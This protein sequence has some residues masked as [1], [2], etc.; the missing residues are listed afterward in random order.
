MK[1]LV[2]TEKYSPHPSQKDGGARV[3]ESLKQ[4][5]GNDVSI[6]QFGGFEKSS[7][8]WHFDYPHTYPCRFMNRIAN[9]PFIAEKVKAVEE[10]FTHIIFI[11]ASMQFGYQSSNS[12]AWTFPMF[13]TPSYL[14]SGEDIPSEYT[15]LE[16]QVLASTHNILSPS[17]LEKNQIIDFYDIPERKIHVVP[18]GVDTTMLRPQT[19]KLTSN[20]KFCSVGSI[21]TQKNTIGLL[22]LFSKAKAKYPGATL[23][24][25]GPIQ[26]SKYHSKVLEVL[27]R[28]ELKR[29]V[30]FMG[31][32]SPQHISKA[33]E[34]CHI[35]ISA[36]SYET[37]GRSIFETLASGLPNIAYKQGN[38]AAEFLDGLPYAQFVNCDHGFLQAIDFLLSDLTRLSRMSQE[39]GKLFNDKSLAQQLVA[40]VISEDVI[41][42]SDFDGTLYHKEDEIKTQTCIDEFKKFKVKVICS[43]R[44]TE[45][46]LAYCER[47]SLNVDW[48]VSYGGAVVSDGRGNE[49][50]RVPIGKTDVENIE[51]LASE[52]QRIMT[53]KSI[54]QMKLPEKD[55]PNLSGYRIEVYQ[56]TAFISDWNASKFRAVHN[57]LDHIEWTGQVRVYGD[58]VYD[59]ELINYYDG[60]YISNEPDKVGHQKEI[61]YG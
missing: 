11:H 20:P 58:G 27:D 17:H 43:A 7:A 13:L 45:S 8:T 35:H 5:L 12:I 14:A 51:E 60:T 53:E 26:D 21:K 49:I 9:G 44:P 56:G 46:L 57:L 31:H 41:A 39:I 32:I 4:A 42:I 3:V 61:R 28:L 55:L 47:Y 30:E 33:L 52:S 6:M 16:R 36:S 40:K 54:L 10:R 23:K 38:A 2:I 37:F 22:Q 59:R 18:R 29:D 24:L 19:R 48:I 50:W 15:R 25:I 1:I 34:D